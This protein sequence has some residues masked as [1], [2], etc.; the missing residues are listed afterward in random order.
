MDT[1]EIINRYR[2]VL[3]GDPSVSNVLKGKDAAMSKLSESE[4]LWGLKDKI[5]EAFELLADFSS[6][7]PVSV[8]TTVISM[9]T[10][11]LAY[12]LMPIDLVPDFIPVAGLLDDAAVLSWVFSQCGDTLSPHKRLKFVRSENK[13]DDSH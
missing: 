1:D 11:A 12:F 4:A 2:W 3:D 7:R 8:S 13:R 9:L 5:A 10:G 6:G